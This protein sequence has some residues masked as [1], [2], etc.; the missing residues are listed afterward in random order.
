M[1]DTKVNERLFSELIVIGIL[2]ALMTAIGP[3]LAADY[4][5][6]V[7]VG[8]WIKYDIVGTVPSIS[9][10]DWVILDVQSVSGTEIT[11]L[12]TVRY[13]DGG[14]EANPITWDLESGT[15]PWVIPAGLSKG[16]TFPFAGGFAILNDTV[17]RVYAGAS[18]SVN[19]LNLSR[20]EADTEMI[21]YWDQT[22]GVLVE[23]FLNKSSLNETWAGGYKAIETNMWFA[24][25]IAA[26]ELSS[27]TPMRGETVTISVVLEDEAENPIEGATVNANVN[28][29]VID[30]ADLG[31]GAYEGMLETSDLAVGTYG[32]V[33]TAEK[34]GY[35]L[36]Q[37]SHTLTV[38][39]PQLQVAMQLST[40]TATRGEVMTVSATVEDVAGNPIAGAT[41]TVY[42]GDKADD[43]SDIGDG[44]YQI[45][46]D[47]SDVREGTYTV[48]VA[49]HKEDYGPAE[50]SANLTVKAAPAEN[51]V[52]Y[53]PLY[54]GIAA[55]VIAIAAVAFY[56][57][58]RR[59]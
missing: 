18:R 9:S 56:L 17:G 51:Q 26:T 54:G 55:I 29:M 38:E 46:I 3:I 28:G 8:D 53:W 1:I 39:T 36:T 4:T 15:Q 47:T 57:V 35:Q 5:A 6:G 48:T 12:F 42:I 10:Y 30:L 33:I 14:E 50:T 16:D 23:L 34:A 27:E 32:V 22:T 24:P 37:T 7:E 49:T 40:D 2:I 11:A 59:S 52:L 20:Y 21:A 44:N 13:K 45:T 25:M 19:L 43:L 58:K 41:V 31:D